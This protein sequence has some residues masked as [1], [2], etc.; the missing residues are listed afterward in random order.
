MYN[1]YGLKYHSFLISCCISVPII[2]N[3]L[4]QLDHPAQDESR[5]GWME[6]KRNVTVHYI[7][8]RTCFNHDE[9]DEDG[10]FV[11]RVFSMY[12]PAGYEG[13]TKIKCN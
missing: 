1:K 13:S 9:Y 12:K 8:N 10:T 3:F 7:D 2:P 5:D 6:E 4:Y 11:P